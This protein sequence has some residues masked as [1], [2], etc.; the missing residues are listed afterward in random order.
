MVQGTSSNVGKSILVTAL[1]RIFAR[2]GLKVFPFKSQNMALNSFATP[3]GLEI[4]RAQALQAAAAMRPAE[5]RM[6]PILLK[7]E[8]HRR[9]QVVLMGKPWRTL[10]GKDYYTMKGEMWDTVSTVLEEIRYENDLILVEGAGSPAEINLKADEIVNMRVAKYLHSPVL[11]AADIDRGGVFAFLYG[12][13]ALLD[14]EERRLVK[15]FLI[16]KFRGD[17]KLLEPGLDMLS[18]LTGGRPTLAV[19]PY[20]QKLLLAQEDSVFLE[21][22]RVFGSGDTDIAVIK[23]PHTSNYDDFDILIMENGVQIRFAES[24]RELGTPKA[25]LLPGT[26]T[27]IEDLAWMR[28]TGLADAVLRLAGKGTPVVGI[29]GGFQML[30]REITD[31]DG[32]E[33]SIDRVEGLG[34][35]DLTTRFIRE[36]RTVQADGVLCSEAGFFKDV[37]GSRVSGYEIHRGVTAA[38]GTCSFLKTESGTDG[39]VSPDGRIWGTYFHGIFDEGPF[40]RGW[41]ASLG[42]SPASQEDKAFSLEERRE[43]ELDM[44]ADHVEEALDM[45]QLKRII[46]L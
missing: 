9:S 18:D 30:G 23:F 29:C 31:P 32:V 14:E 15:G 22:R 37:A 42:W 26:K 33:S 25:V 16:N 4:G 21:E 13:L 45:E 17:V 41:L 7:P 5:V 36:K 6:N 11:L 10:S 3:E 2:Q 28:Q 40:R 44:L 46:G 19:I 24:P 12:T 35:L 27:T 8:A 20:M 1:C 38:E 43:Q 34:L 39:A